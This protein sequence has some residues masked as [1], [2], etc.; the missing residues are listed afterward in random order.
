VQLG[1]IYFLPLVVP[2]AVL[3][4]AGVAAIMPALRRRE[5]RLA[6]YA[7]G[8]GVL[9][10]TLTLGAG[11]AATWEQH[12]RIAIPGLPEIMIPTPNELARATRPIG[13]TPALVFLPYPYVGFVPPLRKEPGLDGPR[14]YAA[15]SGAATDLAIASQHPDRHADR[16]VL[17]PDDSLSLQPLSRGCDRVAGSD[18]AR[19]GS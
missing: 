18:E 8:W 2:L 11:H 5:A 1:P 7:V 9:A 12:K 17:H 3:A 16:V 19:R 14:L 6:L 13:G 15:E 4:A 10:W